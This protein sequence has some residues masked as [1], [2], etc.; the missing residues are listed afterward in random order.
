MLVVGMSLLFSAIGVRAGDAQITPM[1]TG[2]INSAY[3]AGFVLGTYACPMIIRKVGH[4]RAFAAMASLLSTLPILHLLWQ[5]AIYWGFLRLITGV[6]LV[7]LYIVVESW[8]NVVAHTSIRGKVFAAYMATCGIASAIGQWMILVGDKRSFLP[9]ALV[10]ILFSLALLPL[11][12]TPVEEP[13][14]MDAPVFSFKEL[15]HVSPVGVIAAIFSGLLSSAFYSLGAVF[16]QG[17]GFSPSGIATFMAA[18]LLGGA[19]SQWPIGH[20]SDRHDR[21]WV[22]FWVC[23]L[24]AGLSALG[25]YFAR[26]HENYLIILGVPLGGLMFAVYGLAVAHVNDLIDPAKTLEVTGG[27]LLLYGIGATAG[28]IVGGFVMEL[29]GDEGLMLYLGLA[30]AL[31]ALSTWFFIITRQ[32]HQQPGTEL[33][34]YVL[35]E[36]GGSQAALK[37]DPRVKKDG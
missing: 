20:F 9:F 5:N 14:A 10:S 30:L 29:S 33:K 28:P 13:E 21:C 2:L 16:G 12:L 26:E 15:F 7:G 25:F 1:I 35:M 27:L 18:T 32:P 4:I 8:L 23:A 19:A 36:S 31:L 37:L 34:G 3:F 11:T 6:C 22:L 17:V 24:G